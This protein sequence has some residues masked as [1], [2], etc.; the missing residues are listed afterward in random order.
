MGTHRVRQERASGD[1]R[2]TGRIQTVLEVCD[3][4]TLAEDATMIWPPASVRTGAPVI[5]PPRIG[6]GGAG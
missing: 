3:L 4:R 6:S 2:L 1:R 5:G